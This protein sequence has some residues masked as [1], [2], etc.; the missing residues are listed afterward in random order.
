VTL[1]LIL[2][3]N[4]RLA[5]Y[6]IWSVIFH[7]TSYQRSNSGHEHL[8]ASMQPRKYSKKNFKTELQK[9]PKTTSEVLEEP[10]VLSYEELGG[11]SDPGLRDCVH[12]V[13]H[14]G[15]GDR[16]CP[17]PYICYTLLACE[18][19]LADTEG[20]YLSCTRIWLLG[21]CRTRIHVTLSSRIHKGG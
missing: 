9:K 10:A 1:S 7:R 3:F 11:L 14:T 6:S 20:S 19:G 2:R 18:V 21:K 4:L 13:V 12:N 5:G 8:I 16:T 15:I 17:I